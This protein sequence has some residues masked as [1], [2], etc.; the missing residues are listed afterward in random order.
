MPLSG[1]T[2]PIRLLILGVPQKLLS[3]AVVMVRHVN[4]L[5]KWVARTAR[6]SYN[7]RSPYS[8]FKYH[9]PTGNKHGWAPS[10]IEMLACALIRYVHELVMD[11]AMV[12]PRGRGYDFSH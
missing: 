3:R 5:E 10:R 6:P 4:S 11:R 9:P 12:W 2:V 8:V 7:A 1:I